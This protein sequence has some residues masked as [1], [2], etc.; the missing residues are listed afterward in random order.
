MTAASVVLRL[1]EATTA[2]ARELLKPMQGTNGLSGA[3]FGRLLETYAADPHRTTGTSGCRRRNETPQPGRLLPGRSGEIHTASGIGAGTHGAQARPGLA[4]ALATGIVE[5][6][7]LQ[8]RIH[9]RNP[10]RK[11][12]ERGASHPGDLP[13][14]SETLAQLESTL[15]MRQQHLETADVIRPEGL[16]IISPEEG[17]RGWLADTYH[18]ADHMAPLVATREV[19]VVFAA[20]E[21]MLCHEFRVDHGA[22]H[23]MGTI[24][25]KVALCLDAIGVD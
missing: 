3:Y 11:A 16:A 9:D 18:A 20:Q 15:H 19:D 23:V 13:I 21:G 1:E 14:V 12:V 25:G 7:Q 2:E 4:E 17:D 5:E 22:P 6:M 24:V 10:N 8:P